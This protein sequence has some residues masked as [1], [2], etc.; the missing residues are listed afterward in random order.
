MRRGALALGAVLGLLLAAAPSCFSGNCNSTNCRG[1]C[2]GGLCVTGRADACGS[3]GNACVSCAPLE[4]CLSSR[5]VLV[6][7]DVGARCAT[8]QDCLRV[9]DSAQCKLVTNPRGTPYPG[10]YCTR[11]CASQS[12][13][14]D[15][16]FC[17]NAWVPFGESD[18]ACWK[19]CLRTADCGDGYECWAVFGQLNPGACWINPLPG[20]DAG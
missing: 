9:G 7:G 2:Q 18:V 16:S 14:P 6:S 4:S 3:G 17:L 1:C 19:S 15:G 20:R 10:G 5:C 12:D 11:P 8:A 13:C